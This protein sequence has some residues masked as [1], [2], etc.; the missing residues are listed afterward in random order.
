M[1]SCGMLSSVFRGS[2]TIFALCAHWQTHTHTRAHKYTDPL[3]S[4][5]HQLYIYLPVFLM[6]RGLD[7]NV[8]MDEGQSLTVKILSAHH[9]FLMFFLIFMRRTHIPLEEVGPVAS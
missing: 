3:T 1:D 8:S 7:V 2:M 4:S 5:M 9:E 6:H